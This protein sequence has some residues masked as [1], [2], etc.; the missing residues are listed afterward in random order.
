MS[1]DWRPVA[2]RAASLLLR[3][4]SDDVVAA[5][6]VVRAALDELPVEVAAPLHRVASYRA[7]T[8]RQNESEE[9]V[10][11]DWLVSVYEPTI[12]AVPREL[13]GKLEGVIAKRLDAPY[14][15]GRRSP[16][17]I[18]APFIRTQEVLIIG[19]RAG[20]GRRAGTIGSPGATRSAG[21]TGCIPGASAAP[22]PA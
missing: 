21:R 9:L 12:R 22:E 1:D 5:L 7:A 8:D 15:P 6:P 20:E 2:A 4:P 18:K 11:H 19:S 13:A 10:A 3:Y 14:S 16:D 17:W